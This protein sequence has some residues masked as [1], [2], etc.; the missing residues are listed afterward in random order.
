MDSFSVFYHVRGRIEKLAIGVNTNIHD[1]LE[2]I[3]A[4]APEVDQ[5]SLN[6]AFRNVMWCPSVEAAAAIIINGDN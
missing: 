4:P 5:T 6:A 1:Y 3:H 2:R